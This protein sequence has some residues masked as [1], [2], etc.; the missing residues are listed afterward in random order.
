[1]EDNSTFESN[2]IDIH[3]PDEIFWR[4]GHEVHTVSISAT[5]SFVVATLVSVV[6]SHTFITKSMTFVLHTEDANNVGN[7]HQDQ[8][9]TRKS[10]NCGT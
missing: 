10:L 3:K 2:A 4:C 1:M 6:Y 9:H 7:G 8:K 5:W